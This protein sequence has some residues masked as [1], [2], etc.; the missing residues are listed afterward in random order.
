VEEVH[1]GADEDLCAELERFAFLIGRFRCE[2]RLKMPSGEWQ[3]FE[4]GWEGWWI[5]SDHAIG[6]EYRMF[7]A[8]GKVIVLGL[9]VR[10]YDAS[11]KQWNIKWL[12]ALSGRWTDLGPEELGGVQFDGTS[13][14]YQFREPMVG[15]TYTRA[16]YTNIS[17]RHFTWKG[18][19][20]EDGDT[21]T[22][23]MVVECERE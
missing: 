13:V 22:E 5:L 21:W 10:A 3:R 15:H 12:D 18:E 23:F 7:D 16:T 1:M 19:G 9:N 14:S 2:A 11:K 4:A 8:E 17:D 6:D 20:S